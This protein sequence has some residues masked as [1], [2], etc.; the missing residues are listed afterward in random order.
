[1][2]C[3]VTITGGKIKVTKGGFTLSVPDG[4][5]YLTN[6]TIVDASDN[7]LFDASDPQGA[8]GDYSFTVNVTP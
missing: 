3:T 1:M 7:L 6:M 5:I 2:R 8:V 4:G